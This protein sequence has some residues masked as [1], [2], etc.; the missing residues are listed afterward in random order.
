MGIAIDDFG[1]GYSSLAYLRQ[2]PA[3]SI[4]LDRRFVRNVG[5]SAQDRAIV[6]AVTQLAEALGM[7][8][9]VEGIE[10]AEQLSEA[11]AAGAQRGQGYLFGRPQPAEAMRAQ[12]RRGRT[13]E[14]SLFEGA[15]A[16]KQH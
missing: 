1:T 15:T 10:T 6:R 11:R 2:L 5:V 16:L 3:N 7:M 13:G 12:L 4:K 8:V 14:L 9:T